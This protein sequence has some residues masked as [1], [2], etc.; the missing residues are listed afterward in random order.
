MVIDLRE[1]IS[2]AEWIA[3]LTAL[4]H[5]YVHDESGTI[6]ETLLLPF[7][8]DFPEE[9]ILVKRFETE[10]RF[11]HIALENIGGDAVDPETKDAF[12]DDVYSFII[13]N[14]GYSDSY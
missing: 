8:T 5:E 12:Q 13:D 9:G 14:L 7:D 10:A 11:M 3:L 6:G 4:S 2:D 1:E